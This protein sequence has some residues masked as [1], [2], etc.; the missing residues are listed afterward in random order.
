MV[1]NSSQINKMGTQTIFHLRSTP[2]SSCSSGDF[3]ITRRQPQTTFSRVVGSALRVL[4]RSL[5][6]NPI[7][8]IVK[9]KMF[10]SRTLS[11]IRIV[12]MFIKIQRSSFFSSF[13]FS[14]SRCRGNICS[15]LHHGY[16]SRRLNAKINNFQKLYCPKKRACFVFEFGKILSAM[17]SCYSE[18]NIQKA[19]FKPVSLPG[20]HSRGSGDY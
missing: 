2:G 12:F 14:F 6:W 3:A 13:S 4:R 18:Q 8:H 10:R 17:N 1:K 15:R 5:V 16:K 19:P 9:W 7:S 20:L 11:L